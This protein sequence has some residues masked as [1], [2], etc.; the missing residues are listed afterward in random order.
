MFKK[1]KNWLGIEGVKVKASIL[2]DFDVNRTALEGRAILSSMTEQYIEELRVEVLEKY[3]RGRRKGKLVDQYSLGESTVPVGRSIQPGEEI[4]IPFT[5]NYRYT[6]SPVDQFGKK[7]F[8]YRGLAGI[9]KLTRN[10]KSE[11]YVLVEVKV[12][13]NA[14]KPYDKVLLI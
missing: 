5:V 6:P 7:N 11:F 14:L 13:S 10:A 2:G 3:Q 12:R 9:A 8:L 4:E 1:V